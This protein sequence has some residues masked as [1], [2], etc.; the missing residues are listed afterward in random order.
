MQTITLEVILRAVF[1]VDDGPQLGRLRQHIVD[2]LALFDSLTGALFFIPALRLELGGRSPW[3][4][5][6]HA[7]REFAAII[8]GEVARRRAEGTAGRTDVLSMLLEARDEQGAPMSEESLAD[9]MFTLL[10]AGHETTASAL[11]WV[12]YHV[13]RRPDV[14][15]RLRAELQRVAGDGRIDPAQLS[16]LEYL[17][18][19]IKESARL[20]PVATNVNRLLAAPMRI[21]GLDLP[22][23]VSVSA[24]IYLIH[25]RAD[26]W[27]DPERFDPDRFIG[28]RPSPYTFFPFGGGVRRCL[29][30]AFATYEMKVVLAQI[31]ARTDLRIA[32]GYRVRSVLRAVTVA[33]S[34]GMPVVMDRRRAATDQPGRGGESGSGWTPSEFTVNAMR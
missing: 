32:P 13:L 7:R 29:G 18:A 10:G 6:V 28:A 14:V 31:L 33:P 26:I 25:H 8:R 34:R 5:F 1:G 27:R 2:M 16:R 4:R 15:E 3:G 30:A 12:L 17:D 19:V 9:E 22:A 11:A 24:A 21:G 20:T 23:G